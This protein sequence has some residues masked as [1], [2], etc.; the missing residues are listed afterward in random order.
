M[1]IPMRAG[2]WNLAALAVV[3][4]SVC[5]TLV[6]AQQPDECR[7]K[8]GQAAWVS[9]PVYNDANELSLKL[10]QSGFLVECIRR[11]KQEHLFEGQKGAAWFSTNRGTF[12]VWFLPEG[13]TFAS[14]EVIEQPESNGRYSYTFRGT[15]QILAPIDSAKHIY[16]IKRG[17]LMFEVWGDEQLAK[18][19]ERV[20]ASP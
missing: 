2:K 7:N 1:L 18:S 20:V 17:G 8:R 13:E 5:L 6:A 15:P 9:S 14:L 11:S 19:L 16:F 3:V 12:E 4:F 10:T